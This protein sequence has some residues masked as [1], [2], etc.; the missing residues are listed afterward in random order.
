MSRQPEQKIA[1]AFDAYL[2]VRNWLVEPMHGNMYQR[3]VPDRY[4]FRK[5]SGARWIDY[6]VP[7]RYSLT[8]AQ[9]HKWPLWETFGL[10]I[11]IITECSDAEYAKLFDAPNWREYWKPSYGRIV[12]LTPI[13]LPDGQS[14]QVDQ[15]DG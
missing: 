13:R 1:D 7:G 8:R 12:D 6:K 15:H 4:V 5:S 3:G 9:R 14:H 2:R 10:G 11:W